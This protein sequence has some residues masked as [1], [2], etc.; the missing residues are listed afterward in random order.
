MG[1]AEQAPN[2][3]LLLVLGI[4]GVVLLCLPIGFVAFFLARSTMR[5]YPNCGM[6]KAG[7]WLG[8]VGMIL[9]ILFIAFIACYVAVI[10]GVVASMRTYP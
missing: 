2:G 4:M 9:F 7:Y 1:P 5:Q 3:V 10:A 6:T 8:L